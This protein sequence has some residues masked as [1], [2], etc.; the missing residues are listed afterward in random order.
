MLQS[1]LVS[2]FELP[3]LLVV[4]A[5][6]YAD[7]NAVE[8]RLGTFDFDFKAGIIFQPFV[9]AQHAV[10]ELLRAQPVLFGNLELLLVKSG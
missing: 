6:N 5:V 4:D 8:N 10:E 3:D 2:A 9:H 1:Q 7:Q